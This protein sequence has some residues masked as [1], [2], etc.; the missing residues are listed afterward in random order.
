MAFDGEY[1]RERPFFETIEEGWEYSDSIGSKWFFYPFHFI[2][3]GNKIISD[4]H[5]AGKKISTVCKHINRFS[6]SKAAQNMD[7]QVFWDNFLDYIQGV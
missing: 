4:H 5:F 6:R 1:K 2:V 3:S 7:A